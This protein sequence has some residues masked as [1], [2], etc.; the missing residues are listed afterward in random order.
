MNEPAWTTNLI[1]GVAYNCT[2]IE[3]T[4]C[5]SFGFDGVCAQIFSATSFWTKRVMEIGGFFCVRKCV[6]SGEVM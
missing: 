2:I 1:D 4:E 5:P 6:M 3:R